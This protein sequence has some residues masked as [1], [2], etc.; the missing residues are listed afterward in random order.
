M[1][2]VLAS[3]NLEEL[4]NLEYLVVNFSD[5]ERNDTLYPPL[6]SEL[7][8]WVG[9]KQA[10]RPLEMACAARHIACTIHYPD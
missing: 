1:R 3:I 6:I 5:L 9:T 7:G 2:D 8:P 4:A 10:W